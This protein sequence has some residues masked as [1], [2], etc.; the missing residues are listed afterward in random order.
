MVAYLDDILIYSPDRETH[1][2]HVREVLTR[3]E[4]NK[5]FA[6]PSKFEFFKEQM[7][8]LGHI[9]SHN[10]V[11]V[12][13]ERSKV[14]KNWSRP[15]TVKSMQ[16]FMGFCNYYRKFI[17][18]YSEKSRELFNLLSGNPKQ[19]L[20]TDHLIQKYEEFK[21]LFAETVPLKTADFG[22]PF[23]L[24][25]DA[26]D[27]ALGAVLQQKDMQNSLRPIANLRIMKPTTQLQKK[28]C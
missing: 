13:K 23:I 16:K 25:T 11:K 26:S 4:K 9:I 28:N 18:N 24:S 2:R 12:N 1:E 19:L 15:Q 3:L 5:L 20:W 17:P 21:K 27:H 10:C 14:L 22:A 7:E 8:F 6:N